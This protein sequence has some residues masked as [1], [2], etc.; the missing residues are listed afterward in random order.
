MH[1]ARRMIRTLSRNSNMNTS[2]MSREKMLAAV[3][4]AVLVVVLVLWASGVFAP[5]LTK[6]QANDQC[7]ACVKQNCSADPNT[8]DGLRKMQACGCT[9]ACASQCKA[10][11]DY[12]PG[13]CDPIPADC[14]IQIIPGVTKTLN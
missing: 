4:I 2:G 10:A 7:I 8:C 5:K 14:S 12:T 1:H 11:N 13:T 6:E 9:G 3:M